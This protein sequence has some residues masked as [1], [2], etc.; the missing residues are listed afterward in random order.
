[1]LGQHMN[2]RKIWWAAQRLV[3]H[4]LR[5]FEIEIDSAAAFSLVVNLGTWTA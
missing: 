3:R 5:R 1:M 4:K 2:R